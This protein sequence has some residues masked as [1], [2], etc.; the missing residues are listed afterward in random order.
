MV[1]VEEENWKTRRKTLG[2]RTRTNNKVNPY[3]ASM[4]GI[5]PGQNWWETSALAT[6]SSSTIIVVWIQSHNPPPPP[7]PL[8]ARGI[9]IEKRWG[10]LSEILKR[11]P[12]KVLE[13]CFVGV[14]RTIF[15]PLRGTNSEVIKVEMIAL[16]LM[17]HE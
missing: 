1:F 12:K 15:L 4:L 2:A 13:F 8:G 10:G 16:L 6:A 7:P 9:P 14:V 17:N 3:M 5:E 11:T